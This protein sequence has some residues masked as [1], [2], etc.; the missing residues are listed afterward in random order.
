M[1]GR[2]FAFWIELKDG[3]LLRWVNLTPHQAKCMHKWTE[4]GI[5]WSNVKAFGWEEM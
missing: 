5:G 4:D 1:S 2:K 3:Q